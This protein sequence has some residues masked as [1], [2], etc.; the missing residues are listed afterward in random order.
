MWHRNAC[1][2]YNPL[3]PTGP[4]QRLGRA[5]VSRG[6]G[7]RLLVTGGRVVEVRGADRAFLRRLG[8][9]RRPAVSRL[10]WRVLRSLRR[11]VRRHGLRE[12]GRRHYRSAEALRRELAFLR[13][14]ERARAKTC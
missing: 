6:K 11:A 5:L 8:R 14:L 4:W 1:G 7:F 3:E 9:L 2:V 10:T 12:A 13:A